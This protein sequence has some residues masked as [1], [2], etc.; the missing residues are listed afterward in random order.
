M[1]LGLFSPFT[2]LSGTRLSAS[3]REVQ[4]AIWGK[5]KAAHIGPCGWK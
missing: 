2:V 4:G 5:I 1:I 3:V